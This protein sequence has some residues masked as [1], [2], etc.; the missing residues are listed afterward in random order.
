MNEKISWYREVLDLEPDSRLFLPLARLLVEEGLAEEAADVLDRG[1]A[2]HPTFLEAGL[3]RVEV[4]QSLGRAEESSA[5]LDALLPIFSRNRGFWKAWADNENAL[6]REGASLALR[7]LDLVLNGVAVDMQDIIRRGIESLEMERAGA[8]RPESRPKAAP[9]ILPLRQE[10]VS[11]G[12]GPKAATPLQSAEKLKTAE[13][14]KPKRIISAPGAQEKALEKPFDKA[15]DR[16]VS[17]P[18]ISVAEPAQNGGAARDRTQVPPRTRSMAEVL[19]EQEQYRDAASIYAEIIEKCREN[20]E[21][22]KIE[23]IENRRKELLALAEGRQIEA[24][25]PVAA[26]DPA[27]P[28]A[29]RDASSA[30]ASSADASSADVSAQDASSRDVSEEQGVERP[31][32]AAVSPAAIPSAAIPSA[33]IPSATEEDGLVSILEELARRM[34][35]RIG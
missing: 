13:S 12:P 3:F 34:E 19:A 11:P 26:P 6:G 29:A 30:D 17:A 1:C 14:L 10:A 20:G 15:A 2:R 9:V 32:A 35:A 7:L 25:Q 23:E 21:S 18:R 31:A 16:P 24:P 5:E 28:E 27:Q 4:L 22:G 33:A 8:G